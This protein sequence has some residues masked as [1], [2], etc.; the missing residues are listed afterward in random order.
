VPEIQPGTPGLD[1]LE[2]W[3]LRVVTHPDG[4][5]AGWSAAVSEGLVPE[6]VSELRELV[7]GNDRLTPEEQ[8]GVYGF[9]YFQRLIDIL[10]EEYPG[11][12]GLL[13]EDEFPALCKAFLIEHPSTSWTLNRLSLGFP[14]WLSVVGDRMDSAELR[15]AADVAAVERAMEEIWDAPFEEPVSAEELAAIPPEGWAE[16]RLSTIAAHRLLALDHPV[17]E[18]MDAVRADEPWSI[19]G[20]SPSWMLV[21]RQGLRRFRLPL[22]QEQADLLSALV[23]GATLGEAL[24][25]AASAEGADVALMMGSVGEWL[26]DFASRGIFSA[27]R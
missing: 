2:R 27:V 12:L 18:F 14:A 26:Q 15:F 20:P 10:T 3:V 1:Q 23:A 4:V 16:L 8:L 21:F 9:A 5:G 11:V 22:V 6:G 7:P 19:A 17:A 25:S 13:G 24:E